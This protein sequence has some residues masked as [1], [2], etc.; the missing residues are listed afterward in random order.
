MFLN[1]RVLL[2]TVLLMSLLLP[3]AKASGLVDTIQVECRL[4][5][6]DQRNEVDGLYKVERDGD[7]LFA[8]YRHHPS[9]DLLRTDDVTFKHVSE[10]ALD[11]YNQNGLVDLLVSVAEINRAELKS[12]NYYGIDQRDDGTFEMQLWKLMGSEN[13]SLK[14]VGSGGEWHSPCE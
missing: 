13:R 5:Y 14:V 9:R 4:K 1:I 10:G 11:H 3:S 7:S 12:I 8:R 2:S 6:A